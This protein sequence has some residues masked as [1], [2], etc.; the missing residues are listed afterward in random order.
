MKGID[1]IR[2]A[3]LAT[4]ETEASRILQAAQKHAEE[5][6]RTGK[7][8]AQQEADQIY[9]QRTR[10][11]EEEFARKLIQLRGAANKEILDKK[12]AR[13]GEVFSL[14]RKKI[15]DWPE[16]QYQDVMMRMLAEASGDSPGRVRVH[17]S[18]QRLFETIIKTLNVNRKPEN[19]LSMDTSSSLPEKGGF[20][21]VAADYEVDVRIATVLDDL[22]REL[23]PE[24]AAKL[25]GE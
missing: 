24:L 18:D 22:E 6:V 1:K 9:R 17:P 10:A 15:L 3:V 25:F 20:V 11:I 21:F 19:Q 12:N 7:E 5:I 14:A 8:A 2:D 4:A 16:Q 23:T 13:L